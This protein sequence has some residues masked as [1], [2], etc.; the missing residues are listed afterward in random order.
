MAPSHALSGPPLGR[1]GRLANLAATIGSWEDDLSHAHVPIQASAETTIKTGPVLT[2]GTTASSKTT[3]VTPV[4]SNQVGSLEKNNTLSLANSF[5]TVFDVHPQTIYS[6]VKSSRV[7]PPSPQKTDM[8]ASRPVL[9]TPALSS[10]QKCQ[11]DTIGSNL[12]SSPQTVSI[13]AAPTAPVTPS[14]L[15]TQSTTIAPNLVASSQKP[16]LVAKPTRS[17]PQEKVVTGTPG[18]S[19]IIL[20]LQRNQS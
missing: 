15:K 14:P 8:P 10:P 1:R 2:T 13:Q 7:V 11:S 18:E 5:N 4:N 12:V 16:Q 20:F 6:P 19:L 9:K 3:S 17:V